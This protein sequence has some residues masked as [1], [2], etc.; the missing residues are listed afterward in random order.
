M[1]ILDDNMSQVPEIAEDAYVDQSAS[2]S[3]NVTVG[4]GAGIYPGAVL[5]GDVG[6]VII[7][8]GSNIQDGAVLH[9]A[10][11]GRTVVGRDVTVGHRA[12]LHGC[13]VGDGSLIGMG[14]VVLDDAVIGKHCLIGAGTLITGR[15][16]IPDNSL[17]YGNPAR[18]VRQL[19]GH[20]IEANRKTAA[21]YRE[22]SARRRDRQAG[23]GDDGRRREKQE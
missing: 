3:D 2:V 7:G 14:S 5:R 20:E 21:L 13:T 19:T 17:V 8:E 4:S 22:L 12:V 15:K 18:I 11:G 6:P 23:A 9:C 1:S 16:V 10:P